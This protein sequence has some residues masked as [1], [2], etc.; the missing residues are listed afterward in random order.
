MQL[1]SGTEHE[2]S[3]FYQKCGRVRIA[4]NL[5]GSDM[6]GPHNKSSAVITA[7]WLR[8]GDDLQLID[9]GR[10]QVGII[11]FF[12]VHNLTFMINN[13]KVRHIWAYV[14]WKQSHRNRDY[15]GRSAIVCEESFEECSVCCFILV[16]RIACRCAYA[17]MPVQFEDITETVFIACPIQ[18]KY[19]I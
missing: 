1:Y 15:F 18:M 9:N 11:Q 6:P 3:R 14:H 5:I 13:E 4:G 7:F 16:Q 2:V 8:K 17:T 19:S 10:M 12:V